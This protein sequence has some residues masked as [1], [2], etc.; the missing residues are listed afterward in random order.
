MVEHQQN[1]IRIEQLKQTTSS[2]DETI[3][4]QIRLLAGLRKDLLAIPISDIDDARPSFNVDEVLAYAKFIGPTTVPPTRRKHAIPA[5]KLE[6]SSQARTPHI[7][8]GIST[9]PPG[10]GKAE[11]DPADLVAANTLDERDKAW[12][13]AQEHFE[14]WPSH[15]VIARGTLANIQ[16]M[17]ERGV[18]P[19]S[20]L[21]VEE[22]AKADRVK[23][24]EEERDRLEQEER[25]RRRAQLFDTGRR[26]TV[27]NDVFNPDD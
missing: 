20:I 13:N 16:K 22:Q 26:R 8:N 21:T 2:L 17:V 12:I 6:E 4:S 9:S 3:K 1:H 14:P 24:E 11:P 18:D 25:E 7:A 5:S 23:K 19:A 15:D 10:T 27:V